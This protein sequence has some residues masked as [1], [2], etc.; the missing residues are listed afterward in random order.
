MMEIL[1][2]VIFFYLF[3]KLLGLAFR[4]T[5]GL[6][7]LVA[8]LLI[9]LA[10]PVFILCFLFVGGVVLLVPLVMMGAAFG[11]LKACV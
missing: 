10:L 4:M 11:I 6:A 1:T 7:K 3:F 9:T 2:V 5:W 8:G